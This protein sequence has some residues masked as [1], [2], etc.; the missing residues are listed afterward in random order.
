MDFS[1]GLPLTQWSK[2][3]IIKALLNLLSETVFKTKLRLVVLSMES[4]SHRSNLW[5]TLLDSQHLNILLLY[6]KYI[7]FQLLL[8]VTACAY[9]HLL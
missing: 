7:K 3:L 6:W 4:G 1:R 5:S 8:N 9:L 2:F